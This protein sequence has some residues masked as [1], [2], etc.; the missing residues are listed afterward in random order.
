M[1]TDL[2]R[3]PFQPQRP[4]HPLWPAVCMALALSGCGHIAVG[5]EPRTPDS[6]LVQQVTASPA[7]QQAQAHAADGQA[8]FSDAPLPAHWWRLF[9]D[10]QLDALVQ[11]AL[12]HNADLRVAAA[13]LER[14]QAEEAVT[15]G[16]ADPSI[17]V[18]GGP[19]YGIP[20]S[21]LDLLSPGYHPK[22]DSYY[23]AKVAVSYDLD[24]A[25]QVRRA[26]EAAHANT[27][28]AEAA[29]DLARVTVA[30]STARAYAEACS[31]TW[32]LQA[33]DR[34]I[35]LQ[36]QA[37]KLTERLQAAGRVGEMDTAQARA[38][39]Q[40]LRAARPP[41]QA[42]HD[43]AVLRLGVLVGQLPSQAPPL[44]CTA[45]PRV[46]QALPVGDGTSLLRRRPD[47]RQA[48]RH[49][50]AA[51]AHIGVAMAERYPHVSFGLSASSVGY[52]NKIGHADTLSW[53]MG[54]LISWTLPNTGVVE[55]R[56]AQAEASDRAA[57]AQFDQVVLK[58]LQETENALQ[59]YAR[60]LDRH[61]ALVAARDEAQRVAQQARRLYVNGKVAF[62]S[63]LDA[64]RNLASAEAA[65]AASDGQLADDQIQLFLA[66]GGGWEP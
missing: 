23:G 59:V 34:S 24:V 42:L 26:M 49:A 25:G 22:N 45:A 50:V 33:T 37:V 12:A 11:Q 61:D 29:R 44:S 1:S 57:L 36:D 55:A 5:P 64:D 6:A 58:A 17:S 30:A 35:A 32:R 46:Q 3:S 62:L 40:Q 9:D 8:L 15:A 52:L 60:E 27:Q 66:L 20:K 65:L 48:E 14:V 4:R 41:L 2:P 43:S 51:T 21:G 47:V 63:T 7:L 10:A 56:V 39:W 31:A 16:A 28:A 53:S 19:S 38:Q 18:G 54:P 13:N